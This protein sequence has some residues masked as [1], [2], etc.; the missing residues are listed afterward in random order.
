MGL[1]D[2]YEKRYYLFD[3]DGKRVFKVIPLSANNNY[4]GSCCGRRYTNKATF[5]LNT[6]ELERFKKVHG[7]FLEHELGQQMTIFDVVQD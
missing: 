2:G 3:K 4:L 1:I 6:N 7:F 5:N